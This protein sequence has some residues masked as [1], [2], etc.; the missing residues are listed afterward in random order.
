MSNPT[1]FTSQTETLNAIRD[2]NRTTGGIRPNIPLIKKGS[3]PYFVNPLTGRVINN[4]TRS[5]YNVNRN[6]KKA[7]AELEQKRITQQ[8]NN[9]LVDTSVI[10]R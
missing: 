6:I 9:K 8:R 1:L 2:S 4:N 3:S 7:N 5:R 10:K